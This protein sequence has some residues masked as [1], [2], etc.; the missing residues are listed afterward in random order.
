MTGYFSAPPSWEAAIRIY[1]AALEAGPSDGAEAA[2]EEIFRLARLYEEACAD[3]GAMR[4][5]FVEIGKLAENNAP[6]KR[7]IKVALR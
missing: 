2:R 7:L 4:S 1:V 5:V 6:I 3:N